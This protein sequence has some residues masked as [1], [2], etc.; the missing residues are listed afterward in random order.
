MCCFLKKERV[1]GTAC[2]FNNICSCLYVN[3]SNDSADT[4]L[5]NSGYYRTYGFSIL[6]LYDRISNNTFSYSNTQKETKAGADHLS[7]R[8]ERRLFHWKPETE[9]HRK[10]CASF[11]FRHCAPQVR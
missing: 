6:K 4:K 1:P 7:G 5:S 2:T 8:G 10:G 9:K 11:T 3:T